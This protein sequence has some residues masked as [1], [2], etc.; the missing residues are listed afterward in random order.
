MSTQ[1][2]SLWRMVPSEVS[3]GE[4][5]EDIR[6][7]GW[8]AQGILA[9]SIDDPRLKWPEREMLKQIATRLYG[10]RT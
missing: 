1:V 9:V 2:S 6:R 10:V 4:R 3:S 7:R 8:R 5:A